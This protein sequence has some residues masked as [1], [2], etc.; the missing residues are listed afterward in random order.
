MLV[1]LQTFSGNVAKNDALL[2]S[3]LQSAPIAFR[4]MANASGRSPHSWA[5]TA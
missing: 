2:R 1:N 5:T 3:F 4:N